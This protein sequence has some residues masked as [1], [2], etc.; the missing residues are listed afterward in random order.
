[1]LSLLALLDSLNEL[2]LAKLLIFAL[3]VFKFLLNF[4]LTLLFS[5]LNFC[6]RLLKLPKL[7][8]FFLR[9]DKPAALV[10]VELYKFAEL[11]KFLE[12][13][14]FEDFTESLLGFVELFSFGAFA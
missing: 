4:L 9:S 3:T 11:D 5:E 1:M 12:F 13:S 6:V 2:L 8:D 7:K 10:A 14:S